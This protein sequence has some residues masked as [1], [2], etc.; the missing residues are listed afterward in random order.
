MVL[1][2]YQIILFFIISLS[3]YLTLNH[4]MAVT[5]VTSLQYSACSQPYSL[6]TTTYSIKVPNT[7]NANDLNIS[8]ISLI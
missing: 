1:I 3:Y 6:C 4:Y 8:F 7:I 2:T 5:V